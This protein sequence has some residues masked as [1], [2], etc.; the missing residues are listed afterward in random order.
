MNTNWLIAFPFE[1]F[2]E[3]LLNSFKISSLELLLDT[4]VEQ[5]ISFEPFADQLVQKA[6]LY[7]PIENQETARSILRTAVERMIVNPLAK[8]R[9][10]N[11]LRNFK[12]KIG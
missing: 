11:N 10:L 2:N 6:G 12:S 4:P 8:E 9:G 5:T 7:W 3:R 1:A